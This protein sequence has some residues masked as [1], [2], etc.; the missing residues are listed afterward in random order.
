[1]KKTLI[2]LL[3]L[4]ALAF[5]APAQ[6]DL[7]KSVRKGVTANHE[8]EA[9]AKMRQAESYISNFYVDPVN[10]D[11]LAEEAI[12]AMLRALDPH[13]TYSTAE[14]TRALN[15]PL[16]G[17]FSG[18]GISFNAQSDTVLVIETIAGG[19]AEKVGLQPG[20]RI[21]M[22]NDTVIAG[23]KMPQND[24][25]KRLRGPKGTKVKVTVYR[26][27]TRRTIDFIITRD[28]IP[29]YSIDA[30]Y[31]VDDHTGYVR[32]LRFADSTFDEFEQALD[33]LQKQG[34]TDLI[35]DLQSNGGGYLN[36]AVDIA[37]MFL[38]RGDKI[39]STQNSRSL[40]RYYVAEYTGS[41]PDE[42]RVVILVDQYTAS[43]SEILS[44]ALQD[45]D[46]AVIVGRRTFGKGL[47]QRAYNFSDGSM[48]RLTVSRYHTPCGRCI[49]KPYTSGDDEHYK[50]DIR[51]RLDS[52]ELT[53]AD[54]IHFDESQIFYTAGGRKVY[55]G[56]GIMPD[57]FVPLDTTYFT[58]YYRDL[59]AKGVISKYTI[60]YFDQNRKALLKQYKTEQQFLDRFVVT[61]AM[62]Q[63]LVALGAE[64]GVPFVQDQ[65]DT[66]DPYM[67]AVIKAILGQDLYTR[68]TY[69]K[70]MNPFSPIFRE[71]LRVISSPEYPALLRP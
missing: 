57:C 45:N 44:G 3:A 70:V 47:V 32:I 62:M 20:D 14:E 49:Q 50:S 16:E 26:P 13:S 64:E 60:G 53:S 29:I 19:P 8:S 39:V 34:M 35:I 37:Q 21:I 4:L 36:R 68:D 22:V 30:T 15:E 48:M 51:D 33:K 67:R 9:A 43:A 2:T 41:F 38:H 5:S 71:G 7:L 69:W 40:P 17:N 46:R 11:S 52:G 18:I 25:K 6:T 66:A 63:A 55:G 54:S 12:R 61:D 23:V 1:M 10:S 59:V 27:S 58:N 42:G 65:Y 56:G 24:I 31:M 28:D